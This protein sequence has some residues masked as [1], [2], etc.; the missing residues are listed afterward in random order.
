MKGLQNHQ[1]QTTYLGVDLGGT[2]LLIGEMN[3]QGQLLRSK[4]W[5]SGPLTQQEA[6][7]LIERC[8]DEFLASPLPGCRPAGIGV[9]MVGRVDNKTG[10]WL[11][12]DTERS[13]PLPVGKILGERYG[14]PCFIDNDV[15]S[16]TKAEMLFGFGRHTKDLVYINVG[17]G[18][19]AGFVSNGQ[20]ICGGHFNAGEVGH[21]ASGLPLHISCICGRPDCVEPIASGL[22]FDRCARTLASRYPD[23]KLHIP[24]EA[25]G[26]RVDV[27]EVF[28]L[29]NTD[30]LC[31][32][33]TDN[34]AQAVANLIM[35][36]IRFSDPDTIVL[37]GGVV[38]DGFLYEKVKAQL[39][40]HTIRYVTNGIHLTAL[41]PHTIGLLGAC[42][43]AVIKL[44]EIQ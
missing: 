20:L 22:G 27:A 1:Q 40:P 9:G 2:K 3:R 42:S 30:R 14:L 19:A 10:T 21:T 34:A 25:A 38:S 39:N 35:N 28:A 17:T 18:I 12:I 31:Q 36:L 8:L 44:E 43:N 7:G 24:P 29:Y 13:T 11:E 37:G 41:D 5:P 16:A 6:L 4:K 23:T 15:R 33:L 26:T 32:V